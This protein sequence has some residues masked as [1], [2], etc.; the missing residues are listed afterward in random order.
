M[1]A[2]RRSQRS[3]KK[4]PTGTILR[5][6]TRKA[7][8]I[9]DVGNPGKG[10]QGEGKGIGPLRKG[11][12]SQFGYDHV[13][14][15]SEG[16]RHLALAKAVHEYGALSVWRKLNAVYVY[17]RNTAPASSAIFKADRNWIYTHYGISAV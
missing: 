8:C 14:R 7:S 6:R 5:I 4:C 2:T 1:A 15:T 9:P 3:Q 11:D 13:T 10:F 12:L 16:R 17:T